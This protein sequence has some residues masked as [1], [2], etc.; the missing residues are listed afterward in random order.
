LLLTVG[1]CSSS[2]DNPA[3]TSPTTAARGTPALTQPGLVAPPRSHKA[4]FTGEQAEVEKA[5]RAFLAAFE[6]KDVAAVT[7][8]Q[9]HPT[10]R[11]EL[12]SFMN[13]YRV[14]LYRINDIFVHGSDAII[15]YEN[16]I[17]GRNVKPGV[18]TTLLGQRDIWSNASGRWKVVSDTAFTPGIPSDLK[19]VTLRLED[20]APISVPAL[21][22]TDF[23][24]LLKNT[25]RSPKG[26]FILRIPPGLP[27]A[28]VLRVVARV[29]ATR[30]SAGTVFPDGITE[31]GAT[32]DVAPHRTGTM[33]F[34]GPLPKGRYALISRA[35]NDGDALPGETATFTVN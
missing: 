6:R 16:A 24:F 17:V 14:R 28:T 34:S 2:S 1:A 30:G 29:G 20:G 13:S 7:A 12:L 26:V 25:G 11:A 3:A 35:G 21:P 9:T 33:V 4:V 23:A 22:N 32:A 5:F 8:A 10:P 15:D 31:M 27:I 18:T 19:S